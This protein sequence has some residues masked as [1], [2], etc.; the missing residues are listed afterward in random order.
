MTKM[1]VTEYADQSRDSRGYPLPSALEPPLAV[2]VV[3]YTAGTAVSAA[4]N[5][6]TR[7]VRVHVDSI[8]SVKFGPGISAAL[9]TDPRF[10]AGQTEYF[11]VTK[12]A[13]A[14]GTMK[15]AAITN[16]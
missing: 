13:V 1:Y 7:L 9:T 11:A 10:V 16:T 2:Q 15:I 8:A 14:L 6:K 3:D 12:E 4:L 5:A